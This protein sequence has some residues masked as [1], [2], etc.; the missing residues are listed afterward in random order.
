MGMP[1]LL[2]LAKGCVFQNI[3]HLCEPS[4][5]LIMKD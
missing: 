3:I 4:L 5:S 2:S 1:A